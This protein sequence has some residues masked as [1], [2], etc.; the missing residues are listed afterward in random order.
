MAGHPHCDQN[1]AA[2]RWQNHFRFDV[3]T[4]AVKIALWTACELDPCLIT[5]TS[6]WSVHITIVDGVFQGIPNS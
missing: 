4:L 5:A 1:R 6:G 3:G 2:S